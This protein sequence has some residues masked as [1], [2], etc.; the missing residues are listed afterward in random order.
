MLKH[1]LLIALSDAPLSGYEMT[2]K[3]DAGMGHFWKASH[4]QVYGELAKLSETGWVEFKAV[5]QS[6]KPDKKIYSIT[7]EGRLALQDWLSKPTKLMAY[8]DELLVKLFSCDEHQAEVMVSHLE[9]AYSEKEDLLESYQKIEEESFSD[10]SCLS[11]RQHCI[12]LTLLNGIQST[13][14][15][16]QWCEQAIAYLSTVTI[17]QN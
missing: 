1:V 13:K 16:L 9:V 2:K 5:S 14:V 15:W 17:K 3:V 4:Q 10:L 11:V 12:Y 8:K 6:G 7:N